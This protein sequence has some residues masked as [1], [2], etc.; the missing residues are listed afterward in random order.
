MLSAL[1]LSEHSYSA[2][3]LGSTTETLEVRH[4]WSSR[5]KE[6]SPSNILRPRQIETELSHACLSIITNGMDYIF[7]LLLALQ[8]GA[9]V[10]YLLKFS[11][12][13]DILAYAS[14]STGIKLAFS[15][16]CRT[17]MLVLVRFFE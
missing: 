15:R 10:L 6:C 3:A 5:T 16:N 4:S 2:S 1:I 11:N 13:E 17:V 9:D 12:I 7:T 14:V 8:G